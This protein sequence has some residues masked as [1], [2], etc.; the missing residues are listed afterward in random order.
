[1]KRAGMRFFW[2]FRRLFTGVGQEVIL[3][4]NWFFGKKKD[5]DAVDKSEAL[6]TETPS[7]ALQSDA[8]SVTTEEVVAPEAEEAIEQSAEETVIEVAPEVSAEEPTPADPLLLSEES[9]VVD[10]QL[11]E[12]VPEAPAEDLKA[13]DTDRKPSRDR[14]CD[15]I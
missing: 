7:E 10:D 4:L 3:A 1:M 9:P 14:G 8:E 5:K 2:R 12:V 13:T 11:E 15:G 6:P